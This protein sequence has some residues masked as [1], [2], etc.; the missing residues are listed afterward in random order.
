MQVRTATAEDLATIQA[1]EV[2]AGR[3][4]AASADP[5]IAACAD[6]PPL[7]LDR[8]A[9][10][11][12]VGRAWVADVDGS[13]AGFVVA[14]LVDGC[15][16]VVAVAVHPDRGRR[17]IGRTLL[18]EVD[19]YAAEAGLQGVTLTTFRDVP[20]N[21]PWYE[22][23]GFRVLPE[24]EIGPELRARRGEEEGFGLPAEM[25]VCMRRDVAP[26]RAAGAPPAS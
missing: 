16:H 26:V 18:A 25:R 9:D 11:V 17:G 10:W 1:V 2:R 13:V 19:R 8:L 24:G 20:W 12:A 5:V 6:H 7:P 15:A 14:D 21:R 4:F 3:L 23:L 22:R